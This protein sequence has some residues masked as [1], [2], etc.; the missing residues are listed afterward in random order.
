MA[1]KRKKKV[2]S[3]GIKQ[4]ECDITFAHNLIY[5][6]VN[7]AKDLVF[8]PEKDFKI[9]EYF[10]NPDLITDEINEIEFGKDRNPFYIEGPNDNRAKIMA[11]L[12][13]NKDSDKN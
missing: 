4:V 10:L 7:Y 5:G 3:D 2:F 6:A 9:T 1:K 11:I 12:N 8:L 13:R